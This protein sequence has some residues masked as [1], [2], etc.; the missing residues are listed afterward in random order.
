VN[1]G[2]KTEARVPVFAHGG[3]QPFSSMRRYENRS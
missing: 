1:P 3:I 2:R